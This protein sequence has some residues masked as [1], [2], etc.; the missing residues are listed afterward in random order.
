ME[1]TDFE[2]WKAREVARLL[3]LVETERRY[4]Q[5]MVATLP[6][7]LVVLSADRSIVSANRAFR[8]TFGVR[9]DELQRKTIEQ[10]IPSNSLIERIRE[11]HLHGCVQPDLYLDIDDRPLRIVILPIRN[12]NDEGELETLLMVEDLRVIGNM[13]PTL[14]YPP[15]T[16]PQSP[17]PLETAEALVAEA[18]VEQAPVE[19]VPSEEI[20]AHGAS[21]DTAI[22]AI[23]WRAEAAT[24][25]F[26]AVWG[27]AEQLLGYPVSHWLESPQFFRERIHPED[28]A[29][30]MAFYKT[31]FPH[32]GD[33]S[34]EFRIV[35]AAG[36]VR[37]VRETVRV[38][39]FDAESRSITG[40]LT[41]I[42]LRKQ[43]EGQLLAAERHGA[44]HTLT[45][46]LA[47]DLNN[48]LMII[49]G[50][51]EE[52]LHALPAGDSSRGDVEQIL[53]ATERISGITDQLLAFTRRYANPPRSV[54]IGLLLSAMG[55]HFSRAAGVDVVVELLGSNDQ[56]WASADPDQLEEVFLAL[57]SS[58]REDARERSRVTIGWE[59]DFISEQL[60]G[61]T[62]KPGTYARIL[63]HDNGRGVDAAKRVTV[64]ESMLAGKDPEKSAGPELAR[65][66]AMVREW[67]GDIAFASDSFRGSTFTVYLPMAHA[68]PPPLPDSKTP[69]IEEAPAAVETPA[70][71]VEPMRET[72]LL[73]EDEPGIRA[74]VR[75]IL[76]R[77]RYRVFEASSGEE[78]LKLAGTL[79]GAI[80]LLVTDVMLPGIGGREIAETMRT[81]N[82]KLRIV[83]IS[84][85]TD[86]EVVRAGLFP[87]GSMF[88][89]KPFT[90]TAL[91]TKVRESLDAEQS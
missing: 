8:Q 70:P 58:A 54:E 88:L 28:C 29:A 46:R 73:V 38:P 72:I 25:Q 36:K 14:G 82:P 23:L 3:A 75:K 40:V 77:E 2:Q 31:A 41:D 30:T 34:A 20:P 39:E 63:I 90:L 55:L 67:G 24:F 15:A 83:Y 5:E 11:T 43:L 71:P 84:G 16:S 86:D 50:Y 26:T 6:I 1:R 10:I 7:A 45:S 17:P 32:P 9:S 87:P 53:G 4:Y 47:H 61:A 65:A 64:F 49:T 48:P 59:L 80:Q 13:L 85:Y 74:L 62:L 33:V 68:E 44:L 22:P 89:Q 60:P 56:V 52:M 27:A 81:S 57:V 19:Q 66:Y 18:P 21:V 12:W 91:I 69:A 76:S 79:Q 42:T 37:W 78:A 35:T 51:G